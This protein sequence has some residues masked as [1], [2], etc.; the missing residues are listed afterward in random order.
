MQHLIESRWILHHYQMKRRLSK[1][2]L[3]HTS[4]MRGKSAKHFHNL[5]IRQSDQMCNLR[6]GKCI[7][8]IISARQ[9]HFRFHLAAKHIHPDHRRCVFPFDHF[10]KCNLRI[11]SVITTFFTIKATEMSKCMIMILVLCLTVN[12]I[13][14][15]RNIRRS[16]LVKRSVHTK[17]VDLAMR[18]ITQ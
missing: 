5:L 13:Y 7:V 15:I 17:I 12:T 9:H 10:C 11:L 16:S 8:Q 3:F 14:R 2:Y 6:S 1:L 4:K 18:Q